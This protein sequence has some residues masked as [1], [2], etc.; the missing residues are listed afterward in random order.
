MNLSFSWSHRGADFVNPVYSIAVLSLRNVSG[1]IFRRSFADHRDGADR[2][3]CLLLEVRGWL[4]QVGSRH[5][6]GRRRLRTSDSRRLS[7]APHDHTR[8][9]R[10]CHRECTVAYHRELFIIVIIVII[11]HSVNS[12]EILFLREWRHIE[13]VQNLHMSYSINISF[14]IIACFFSIFA[15][16]V[17][18]DRRH[19]CPRSPRRKMSSTPA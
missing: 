7:A 8:H 17:F 12:L 13:R 11:R 1:C 16:G 15:P 3:F 4:R 2:R 19:K 5:G 18:T 6:H 10:R 14:S 9:H